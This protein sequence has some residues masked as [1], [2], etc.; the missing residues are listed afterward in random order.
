[1]RRAAREELLARLLA[2][3]DL[4]D[5]VWRALDATS[6]EEDAVRV[7]ADALGVAL[8]VGGD[9]GVAVRVADLDGNEL[10]PRRAATVAD[11]L[12]PDNCLALR[13]RTTTITASSGEFDACAHLRAEPAPVSA[14]CVPISSRERTFG[15][16][17]W[18]G[19]VDRV[20]HP[21]TVAAIEAVAHMLGAQL[22][23][24]RGGRHDE[25]PRVDPLTALLNRRSTAL[26][27]RGL[28]RDLVPFSVG[29]CDLD[30]FGRYDEDHGHDTGDRALRLFAQVLV[31]TLR[32][33]DVVGR[34]AGD[35]FTVAFPNTSAIDAAHALERVRESLVLAVSAGDVPPFTVSCGVSDSNQGD[36]IEAIVET[37]ELAVALAKR[38]GSNRVVIAGEQTTHLPG[39]PA[40]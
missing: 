29:V 20:L 16:I 15:V 22:A 28:V 26:A 35:V 19:P 37:A 7:V 2:R 12:D 25:A 30:G 24:L 17:Q 9:G 13:R 23:I 8:D 3:V 33:D 1:M 10:P 6:R 4:V 5:R 14:A 21:A 27:I 34:T 32:P 39:D 31:A 18:S 40:D 36:S 38:S 11:P